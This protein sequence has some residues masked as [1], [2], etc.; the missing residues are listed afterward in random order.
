[1]DAPWYGTWRRA[2][3]EP[4]PTTDSDLY[5]PVI[6][7]STDRLRVTIQENNSDIETRQLMIPIGG[8]LSGPNSSKWSKNLDI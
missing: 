3:E 1:M 6:Y 5:R 4:I 7:V 2:P 8:S